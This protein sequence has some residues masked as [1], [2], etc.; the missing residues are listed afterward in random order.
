MLFDEQFD[1]IEL[2]RVKIQPFPRATASI[3]NLFSIFFF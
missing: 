1:T 3:I 2:H